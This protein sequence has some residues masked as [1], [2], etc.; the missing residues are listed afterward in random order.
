MSRSGKASDSPDNASLPP[1]VDEASDTGECDSQPPVAITTL[2]PDIIY[3]DGVDSDDSDMPEVDGTTDPFVAL[4]QG[5]H[6]DAIA[7]YFSPPRCVT[8]ARRLGLSG[9][10]SLDLETGVDFRIPRHRQKSL[11]Q[12]SRRE[13][14]MS[15]RINQS[16]NQSII[17]SI[18]QSI[19]PSNKPS[20]SNQPINR[21]N[22]SN[23]VRCWHIRGYQFTDVFL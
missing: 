18:S 14:Q 7:E 16:I 22:E 12:S 4:E 3:D 13:V 8:V 9:T 2:P 17:H 11:D 23:A 20:Q 21:A 15:D 19:N 5:M 6:R 1:D 10:L